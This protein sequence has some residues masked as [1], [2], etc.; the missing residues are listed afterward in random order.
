MGNR[1]ARQAAPTRQTRYL[2]EVL[3][4]LFALGEKPTVEQLLDWLPDRW[5]LNHG[6]DQ[7]VPE[8][9]AG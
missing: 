5:L 8:V 4:T 2:R 7:P 3:P 9:T 6:R 1:A